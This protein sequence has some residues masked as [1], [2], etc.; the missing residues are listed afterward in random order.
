MTA[1]LMSPMLQLDVPFPLGHELAKRGRGPPGAVVR[2]SV[3]SCAGPFWVQ[4]WTV[5]VAVLPVV[6]SG[7]AAWT[8]THSS[9]VPA[10]A[11]VGEA[12]GA[13]LAAEGSGWH[14]EVAVTAAVE[15]RNRG[16]GLRRGSQ[17]HHHGPD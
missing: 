1:V 3:T 5:Q 8:L 11:T 10:A 6:M 16:E 14:W 15:L 2:A 4:A 12:D 17:R 9:G 7:S 13:G